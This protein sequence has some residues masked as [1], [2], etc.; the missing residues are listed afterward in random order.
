MQHSVV[1]EIKA[2]YFELST[3][4]YRKVVQMI[5]YFSNV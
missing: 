1:L 2:S 5:N 4:T 3:A